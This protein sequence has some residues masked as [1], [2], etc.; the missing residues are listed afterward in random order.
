MSAHAAPRVFSIPAG[1]PFLETLAD[2]LL[3][4]RLVP[5]YAWNG[6]PLT[7]ADATIFVPTRRSA[8]ELRAVFAARVG[9]KA[10]AA[11]AILPVIRP[12]GDFDEDAVL[13]QDGAPA[14]L[15]LAPPI[16][17][18]ERL[19]ALAPLVQAWKRR[20]PAHVAQLFAEEVVVPSSL[21][22]AIWLARDLAALMDEIETEGVGWAGLQGLVREDL[23]NW[24]QVTLEFLSIVTTVW[25]QVL[26]AIDRSNPAAHRS[27]MIDAEAARLARHPPSGPV[28]AAGSTGSIPA[29]ARLLA[30]IARLPSGAVILPGLDRRLDEPSWDLIGHSTQPASAFGHPQYGLKKLIATLGIA[31][32]DIQ[33]LALPPAPLSARSLV[34]SEALRPAETTERW[35]EASADVGDAL[36]VGALD[37]V[38]LVEAAN[39]REEAIAIAVALR[40]A[41]A[42]D[43]SHVALVTSDRELARRVASE[44]LRFGIHADDSGG[45]PLARTRPGLLLVQLLAAVFTPGDPVPLLAL[46]K[47][48]LF[49]LGR[50]RALVRDTVEWIELVALRGGTGRPDVAAL[51]ELFDRRLAELADEQRKPF[52]LRR[53]TENDIA[54]CR[55]LIAAFGEATAPLIVL[56]SRSGVPMADLVAAT[57]TAL[58]AIGRADD[59]GLGR[60]YDGDAGEGL[61]GFLRNLAAAA[62]DMVVEPREWEAIVAALLSGD[63]VKPSA[64]SDPR[65]SIW[66]ALEARLL[67]ADLLVVGGL[68]EGTWPRKAEAD[69]FM[70]RMM[71]T[72]IDLEPPERRIGLAAHDF[73]MAMG[74]AR[75][76]LT[77]AA[78]AGDAPAVPSRWLQRLTTLVGEAPAKAMRARG[79][80]YLAWARQLDAGPDVPFVER[81]RPVPPLESRP[82]GFSVTEVETLRR[83]P[84]AIYARRIL[85]LKPLDPLVRD[86]GAAERGTLFHDILH[87]FTVSGVDPAADS[88]LGVLVDIA[89]AAFDALALPVD[90][91]AVWWPRFMAM[92]PHILAFERERAPGIRARH[93]ED[94]AGATAIGATG[95]T[96]SGYADR[97][98][99]RGGGLADILDYKTGSN[100]SKGQAHTLLSPQL[101]LEGAL[102]R[103]GAFAGAGKAEPADLLYVRLK[104]D[105]QVVPDSILEFK[106]ELRSAAELSEEAWARLEKL[107]AHYQRPST[108]YLSR[109]LPFREGDTDGDYDHLARVLEWS[110]GADEAGGGEGEA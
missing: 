25:P 34:V 62:G 110:A 7:L 36:A 97:I 90:V 32:A 20:L 85:D 80:R 22:D 93:A 13:F 91:E 17:P 39:E 10:G 108:G 35:V 63:T 14:S 1:A 31:R 95:V 16:A 15:D 99:L 11:S 50:R 86:P 42:G 69:R 57:V 87:R 45:T 58:E 51:G 70:S 30:A 65:V 82:T 74:A 83:D 103:R 64:G 9:S 6:D 54:A 49:C 28:I 88:A 33:D 5:G 84:Y 56:R 71:K 19:M 94:R 100:P 89:R 59:G 26:E 48:P 104:P 23:A 105:G 77:R 76:V 37:G 79:D 46:L 40:D 29:T 66:G 43:D 78:R 96:L 61:V 27:A 8:R 72:G 60:L 92:A 73:M 18:M 101:A 4:G 81:P 55:D 21:A 52:W 68:N 107:V 75:L 109:A 106:R 47:H 38:A 98:D 24:W 12:L 3:A 2:A 67:S 102:L 53:L 44:L 41:I